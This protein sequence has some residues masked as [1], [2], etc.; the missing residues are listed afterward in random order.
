MTFLAPSTTADSIRRWW[1]SSSILTSSGV[2]N[3]KSELRSKLEADDNPHTRKKKTTQKKMIKRQR[4]ISVTK[5]HPGDYNR[6]PAKKKKETNRN[7]NNK[8]KFVRLVTGQV[9]PGPLYVMSHALK[10][11]LR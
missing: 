8:E 10:T 9:R 7:K 4:L 6:E 2:I 5:C 3:P 1:R 11:G